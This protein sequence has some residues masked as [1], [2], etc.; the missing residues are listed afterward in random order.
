MFA[1][2]S[3]PEKEMD[4]TSLPKFLETEDQILPE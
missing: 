4:F 3:I 1:K 2:L